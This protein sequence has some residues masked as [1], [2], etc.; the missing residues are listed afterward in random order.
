MGASDERETAHGTEA[1]GHTLVDG[2]ASQHARSRHRADA[3]AGEGDA[4]DKLAELVRQVAE[5]AGYRGLSRELIASVGERELTK[6]RNLKEAVKATRSKLH[7]VTGAYFPRQQYDRW[8]VMLREAAASGNRENVRAACREIMGQHASTRERLSGLD[9]LYAQTLGIVGPVASVIDVACGLNPL[10]IPW[11]PLAPGATYRAYDV[12]PEL[13]AFL[14]EAMPLLGVRGEAFVADVTVS[15]PAGHADVALVCKAL[16]CL[17][18]LDKTAG[19]RLLDAVDARYLLVTYPVRSLGGRGKGM[20]A[21]YDAH[22]RR[23]LQGRPWPVTRYEF[24]TE[25]AFVLA[26]G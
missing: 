20:V 16:P 9:A 25:L 21:T 8:L 22:M 18:Q 7:Q 2:P 24:D 14:N 4:P 5:G 19:G 12:Y 26:K 17:E 15:P 3:I 13:A 10:A 23:L 1:P 11:M 6:R